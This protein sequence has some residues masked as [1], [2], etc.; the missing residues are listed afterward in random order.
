MSF[1]A[2]VVAEVVKTFVSHADSETL[3]EFRYLNTKLPWHRGK[4]QAS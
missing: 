1:A 2:N 4:V 3:D